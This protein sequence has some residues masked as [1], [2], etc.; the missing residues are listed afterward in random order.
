MKLHAGGDTH[1]LRERLQ[2]LEERL[3]PRLF[4]RIHRSTIVRI[5]RIEAL[6]RGRR[7][8]RRAARGRHEAEREPGASGGAGAEV[9]GRVVTAPTVDTHIKYGA[10]G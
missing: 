3:D 7:R 4:F 1:V 2:T 9:G 6:L 10:C 5:D 8:L